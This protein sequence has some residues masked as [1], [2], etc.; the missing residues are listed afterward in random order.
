MPK[1][2]QNQLTMA[3][4]AISDVYTHLEQ[5]VFSDFVKRLKTHPFDGQTVDDAL[6]WQMQTLNDLHL[7]N[8]DLIKAVSAATGSAKGKLTNL[9]KVA[10]YQ[11]AEQEYAKLAK[12]TGVV[13]PNTTEQVLDGYLKQT[14]LDLDN[15]VNQTL[16]TTNYGENT[17]MQAFQQ[18]VKETTANVITGLRTP[19]RAIA[20]TIYKWRGKGISTA[21]IDRGEHKWS[22]ESYAR[23]VVNTTSNRAFQAVRDQAAADYG[24]DTFLMSSH[25][26]SRPA[27]APIQG[28]TVTTRTTGFTAPES[29]EYFYPLDSF[30][31]GE[32]G[33][34][35]GINCHHIK[36]PY[37]PGVNTN[38]QEQFDTADSIQKG[39]VVQ[40]Q[41][42]LER[43]TR[44]YKNQQVLAEQ[45]GDDVGV[46]KYKQ[47]VHKQQMALRQLVKNNDFLS[48]DYSREKD[49]SGKTASATDKTNYLAKMYEN[50][51]KRFGK[52]G[53]PDEEEFQRIILAGG[54]EKKLLTSYL[55][56]R[57]QRT[58]EPVADFELYKS[59]DSELTEKLNGMT[60]ADG[61]TITG[62]SLHA[63]DR[64]IGT[65]YEQESRKRRI[66]V[67]IDKVQTALVNGKIM[68]DK[69]RDSTL[70]ATKQ[71]HVIVNSG[72]LIITV[73]PKEG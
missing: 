10:G 34:T 15:N 19:E 70:F 17:A 7:V 6:R 53:L 21:L 44:F 43:R 38:N 11:V 41:R 9:F 46:L 52:H 51:V 36:W 73:I 13:K 22:L 63:I 60:T 30:G 39:N 8:D 16:I 18:I 4:A 55:R 47:L 62:H 65:R 59:V 68:V 2:T 48:R 64:I 40:T 1:V 33:G 28:K 3:Q 14:F 31:Y 5:Q 58:V 42:A 61:Q 23:M 12:S 67:D 24:V 20:D 35:F 72:G 66:G 37:I 25:A 54:Q 32:P 69:A 57:Q 56:A 27:C 71:V 45:L 26:A 50:Q 49:Y 29:G